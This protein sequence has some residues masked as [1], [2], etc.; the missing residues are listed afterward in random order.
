[1]V[2][3][4]LQLLPQRLQR[5]TYACLNRTKRRTEAGSDF[6]MTQ[7]LEKGQEEGIALLRWQRCQRVTHGLAFGSIGQSERSRQGLEALLRER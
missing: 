5:P 4:S 6:L 3:L 1:M 2:W 7:S